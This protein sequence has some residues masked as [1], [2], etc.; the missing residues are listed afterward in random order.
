MDEEAARTK[1]AQAAM[2]QAEYRQRQR[3]ELAAALLL[4][5][6]RPRK[7]SIQ[8]LLAA[9]IRE[10]TI[11]AYRAG[12]REGLRDVALFSSRTAQPVELVQS[13]PDEVLIRRRAKGAARNYADSYLKRLDGKRE[14]VRLWGQRAA[15]REAI[16]EEAYRLSRIAAT[17]TPQFFNEARRE[18]IR[19]SLRRSGVD[20]A[21]IVR[22]WN[23][24]LDACPHCWALDGQST[25]LNEPYSSGEEPGAVHPFCRCVEVLRIVH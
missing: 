7:Q 4:L 1:Q 23:A 6:G 20:E 5:W 2:L 12:V 22:V 8:E 19:Q 3:L 18:T 9:A 13:R 25:P 10:G 16:G 24:Q 15:A 14:T 17:E 21:L 11:V